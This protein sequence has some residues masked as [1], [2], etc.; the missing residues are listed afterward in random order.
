M[1]LY[2]NLGDQAM[3][4]VKPEEEDSNEVEETESRGDSVTS[5]IRRRYHGQ[6]IQGKKKKID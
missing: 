4:P 2:S 6:K 1:E 3:M 5:N